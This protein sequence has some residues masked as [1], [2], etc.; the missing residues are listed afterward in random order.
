MDNNS[1]GGH[2]VIS[3]TGKY[4]NFEIREHFGLFMVIL[5]KGDKEWFCQ[6][7]DSCWEF[8]GLGQLRTPNSG[9]YCYF[10]IKHANSLLGRL[11]K[12]YENIK[13]N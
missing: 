8:T 12:I 7:F 6:E 10:T 4:D 3:D 5:K 2:E 9:P 1:L 13:T 11:Y